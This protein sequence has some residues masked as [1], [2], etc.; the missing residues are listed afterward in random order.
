MRP[1]PLILIVSLALPAVGCKEEGNPAAPGLP[2]KEERTGG[3]TSTD[4]SAAHQPGVKA[5]SAAQ[6]VPLGDAGPPAPPADLA[7][8]PM[9]KTAPPPPPP[10]KNVPAPAGQKGGTLK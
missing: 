4:N 6:P 7:G 5:P 8:T 3:H 2:Q 9:H 1:F 10:Q